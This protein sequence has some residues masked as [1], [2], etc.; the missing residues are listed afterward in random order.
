MLRN[1]RWFI[2][3]HKCSRLSTCFIWNSRLLVYDVLD[4]IFNY[5]EC[6][7]AEKTKYRLW[8]RKSKKHTKTA[9]MVSTG[10][11]AD[12]WPR[13]WYPCLR[14]HSDQA[15][16]E[17]KSPLQDMIESK[18]STVAVL[19][20]LAVWEPHWIL[21]WSASSLPPVRPT[22]EAERGPD[23]MLSAP[24]TLQARESKHKTILH[25]NSNWK[26]K[27]YTYNNIRR[28]IISSKKSCFQ[29]C[30]KTDLCSL[31]IFCCVDR[32][33]FLFS[34]QKKKKTCSK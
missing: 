7:S 30:S 5:H 16:Q 15:C 34:Y 31:C 19:R 11:A 13:G 1:L 14:T 24:L 18:Q 8:I 29:F 4:F 10:G 22:P 33:C 12:T 2:A 17:R 23:F 32:V 21:L 27:K 25:A 9:S 3:A 20:V 6:S 26:K 28:E